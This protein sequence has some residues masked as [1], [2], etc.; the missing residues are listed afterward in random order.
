MPRQIDV[1]RLFEATVTVFAEYGYHAATTQEIAKRSGVNE[2][3]LFRRYGG[4]AALLNAALSHTLARTPFAE[5][6]VT[7]DVAA[8]LVVL[9][10]AYA[11]TVQ[12][13][14]GAALTL[15]TEAPRH[16]ELRE[17]V[18]AL[19]PNLVN[20]ARVIAAHQ[21][22]GHIAEGDPMQ[23]LMTLIAPIMAFGL[24]ARTGTTTLASYD[25]SALV[26]AF[27]DGHRQHIDRQADIS[28]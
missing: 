14:G 4:K 12:Q 18:A 21:E 11:E 7:D 25:P 22:R 27:I 23:T 17:A 26:T 28:R 8:D 1:D 19:M 13:Y 20:A 6:T 15:L 24:W 3:T 9:V 5:M 16:P 2:V 10:R